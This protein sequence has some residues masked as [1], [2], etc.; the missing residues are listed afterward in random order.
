MEVTVDYENIPKLVDHTS[1]I[2]EEM[3]ICDDHQMLFWF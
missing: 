2:L 3:S 1:V